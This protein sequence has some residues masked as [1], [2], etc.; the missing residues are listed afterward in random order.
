MLKKRLVILGSS[1]SIG[2]S[3]LQVVSA[4][5]D[6]F[7]VAGLAVA[8]NGNAGPSKTVRMGAMS[9]GYGSNER[10]SPRPSKT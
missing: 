5:E 8:T 9:W 10:Q 2:E 1:G 6:R 3:A 7:E 4:L